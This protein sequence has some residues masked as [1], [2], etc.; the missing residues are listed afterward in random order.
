MAEWSKALALGASSKERGF[1]PHSC[2]FVRGAA[3]NLEARVEHEALPHIRSE[4]VVIH[5]CW[6]VHFFF[7]LSVSAFGTSVW[8]QSN[9]EKSTSPVSSVGRAPGS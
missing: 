3:R 5:R 4:A 7:Y 9:S 1:E 8:G 2:H 6:R